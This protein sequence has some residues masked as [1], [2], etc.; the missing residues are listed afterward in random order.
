MSTG[1]DIADVVRMLNDGLIPQPLLL[2]MQ[3]LGFSNPNWVSG[4]F[5]GICGMILANYNIAEKKQPQH[6]HKHH[7]KLVGVISVYHILGG[8]FCR[9]FINK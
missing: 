5:F 3:I 8:P 6:C 7:P 4:M 9:I 2:M 1:S